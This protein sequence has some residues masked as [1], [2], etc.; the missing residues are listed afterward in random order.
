NLAVIRDERYKYVHF[1][2]LPPLFF[3]LARDPGELEDRAGDPA[4]QPLVLEYARKLL[5]WRMRSEDRTLTRY[6]LGPGG[7]LD[8]PGGWPLYL[9]PAFARSA[10]LS[11]SLPS[12]RQ[13]RARH[14][15]PRVFLPAKNTWMAGTSPAMT[16][17][18]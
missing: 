11:I 9:L 17:K 10:P 12:P 18:G 14:G 8:R 1:A 13:P 7:V 16:T 5:S 4:Y 2:A 15:H 3:D 6:H